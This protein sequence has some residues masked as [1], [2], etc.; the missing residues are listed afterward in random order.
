[1][2]KIKNFMSKEKKKKTIE[3]N[4]EKQEAKILWILK[5]YYD[6]KI[7]SF[8]PSDFESVFA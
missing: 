7:I 1:M 3:A 2:A 5:W 4:E 6:Q 8:F